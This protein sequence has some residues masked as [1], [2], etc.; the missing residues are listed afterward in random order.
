MEKD[1]FKRILTDFKGK[2]YDSA[3]EILQKFED[4]NKLSPRITRC[5]IANSKCDFN[6]LKKSVEIAEIDWRDII[7]LAEDYEFQYN[8]PFYTENECE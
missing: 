4:K 8:N 3:I 6:Q 7:D 2:D 1:I 5:I